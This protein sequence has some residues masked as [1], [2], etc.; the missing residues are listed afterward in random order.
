MRS[1]SVS[2]ICGFLF[3]GTAPLPAELTTATGDLLMGFYR[4]ETDPVSLTPSVVAKTYVYNLGPAATWRENT[5]TL[6]VIG[7]IKADLDEALGDDWAESAE[8]RWGIVASTGI[9]G[10]TISGDPLRSSY[11]SRALTTFNPR[12]SEGYTLSSANRFG[13]ANAINDFVAAMNHRPS[14]GNAAGAIVDPSVTANFSSFLPPVQTTF[15]NVGVSPLTFFGPGNIGTSGSYTVEAALDVYRMIHST[16]EADLTSGLGT[17]N[18][19]VGTAQYIGTFTI[20]S[21]GTVRHDAAT[22]NPP[23]GYSGWADTNGLSGA[24]R[25]ADADPDKDGL[26]NAVEFVIGGDPRQPV[27][28]AKAPTVQPGPSGTLEVVFPR[29]DASAYLNPGVEHDS[30]LSGTWTP[31]V[32]GTGGVTVVVDNNFYDG[33]TD[34]VTVR[35]PAAG[36]RNFARL[37]V[38]V[39]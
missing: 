22:S 14:G 31:A 35:I 16:A 9:S 7:N 23:S 2:A 12:S 6:S 38:T 11:Y 15:F 25:E 5:T 18:A 13:T 27:D 17:G 32:A 36:V 20:D 4:V 1:S 30:D 24:D 29:T 8:V 28:S 39:P 34:R 26:A 19:V 37:R 3:L 10:S 33:T 21:T